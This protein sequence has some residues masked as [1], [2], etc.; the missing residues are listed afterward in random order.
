MTHHGPPEPTPQRE[1]GAQ[2]R[3]EAALETSRRTDADQPTHEQAEIEAGGVDQQA[4]P[5]A[6]VPAQ[7]H[8]PHP[9]GL[10]EMSKRAFQSFSA[11]P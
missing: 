6:S 10:I 9:T 5:N 1:K 4:L 8:A 2:S 3:G 11:Q 7:I